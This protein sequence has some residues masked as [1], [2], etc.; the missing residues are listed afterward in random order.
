MRYP[1]PGTAPPDA[2]AADDWRLKLAGLL[3]P[4]K[5]PPDA[6]SESGDVG[7]REVELPFLPIS[8]SEARK[9]VAAAPAGESNDCEI[10]EIAEVVD[11]LCLPPTVSL[12]YRP[13]PV[14][15]VDLGRLAGGVCRRL[16]REAQL[17]R[18]CA[19]GCSTSGDVLRLQ[20]IRHG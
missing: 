17:R 19:R 16:R 3:E 6:D 10:A 18:L 13:G 20:Q 8:A 14:G 7:E 4:Q 2:N 9:F 5:D 12:R 1:R 15:L 11:P